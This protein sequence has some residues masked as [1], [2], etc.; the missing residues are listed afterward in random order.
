MN[1]FQP[2]S[3][4]APLPVPP[5][6][7][8]A[9]QP[10]PAQKTTFSFQL[11]SIMAHQPLLTGKDRHPLF[12]V[13]SPCYRFCGTSISPSGISATNSPVTTCKTPYELTHLTGVSALN[14]G[15]T[16]AQVGYSFTYRQIPGGC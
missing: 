16:T 9:H 11:L 10:Q 3:P 8:D 2:H 13:T 14:F 4:W 7:Q 15:A 12:Q 6:L 5:L 1:I